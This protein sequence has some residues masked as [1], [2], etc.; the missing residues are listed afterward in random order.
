VLEAQEALANLQMF[1]GDAY[2]NQKEL[3]LNYLRK[4]D[5]RLA[6]R[7]MLPDQMVQMGLQARAMGAAQSGNKKVNPITGGNQGGAQPEMG[8]Q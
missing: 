4:V 1:K 5:A 2:I 8:G 6:S 3:R 7:L